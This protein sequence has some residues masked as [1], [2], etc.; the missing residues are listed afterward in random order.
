MSTQII[1]ID[2]P[3][4]K[5]E[6]NRLLELISNIDSELEEITE[7]V[8]ECFVQLET[9][10]N[11]YPSKLNELEVEVVGLRIKN[12][13]YEIN[14]SEEDEEIEEESA[15][16]DPLP[17]KEVSKECKKIY[18]EIAKIC[19]PDITDDKELNALFLSAQENLAANN[20]TG[21]TNILR[22]I[23]G[24][25]QADLPDAEEFLR[26]ELERVRLILKE[27]QAEINLFKMKSS[28]RIMT[29]YE[30]GDL[31]KELDAVQEYNNIILEKMKKLA[32][33]KKAIEEKIASFENEAI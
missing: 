4:Y 7:R 32:K 17:K 33:E 28:Y 10:H 1:K 26:E 2:N 22:S 16:M 21:L 24:E 5:T 8:E 3:D 15:E 29:K 18:Q 12:K 25:A 19:H 31:D 6:I 11:F 9:E 23:H 20:Y 30:S 27:K 13:E 14:N